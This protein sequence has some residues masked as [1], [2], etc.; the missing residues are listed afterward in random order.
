MGQIDDPEVTAAIDHICQVTKSAGLALGSFGVTPA[1]VHADM[2][3]GA[4]LICAGTDT[5]MLGQSAAQMLGKIKA[6]A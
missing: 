4:T 2:R 1:A 5:L 3:R 6:T